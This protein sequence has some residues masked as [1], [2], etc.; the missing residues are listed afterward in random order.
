MDAISDAELHTLDDVIATAES[1]LRI[2]LSPPPIRTLPGELCERIARRVLRKAWNKNHCFGGR[3]TARSAERHAIVLHNG[4][5]IARAILGPGAFAKDGDAYRLVAE[6]F[7]VKRST[8]WPTWR[9]VVDELRDEW[10]KLSTVDG[11]KGAR[12]FIPAIMHGSLLLVQSE[13]SRGWRS[14]NSLYSNPED[15]DDLYPRARP[16]FHASGGWSADIVQALIAAGASVNHR[17]TKTSMTALMRACDEGCD[18]IVQALIAAGADVNARDKE[19]MTPL[20]YACNA[21]HMRSMKVWRLLRAGALIHPQSLDGHTAMCYAFM[22]SESSEIHLDVINLLLNAG[23]D[24]NHALFGS[25]SMLEIASERGNLALVK[26]L[27]AAGANVNVKFDGTQ[28][29]QKNALAAASLRGHVDVVEVLLAAGAMLNPQHWA[30]SPYDF[31]NTA[32]ALHVAITS[33]DRAKTCPDRA[34]AVVRTLLAARADVNDN[35]NRWGVPALVLATQL[36][37]LRMMRALLDAGADVNA[38][39]LDVGAHG[40]KTALAYAVQLGRGP[41]VEALRAAGATE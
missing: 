5:S 7:E 13:L 3:L 34:L 37:N 8:K 10:K 9:A 33:P 23:A 18:D 12:R 11:V 26:A 36:G 28:V 39:T 16:L 20:M 6:L 25:E 41:V 31:L 29:G 27:L 17:T 19:R 1:Q 22:S 24:A 38:R 35:R 30:P 15:I 4:P 21:R 32:S 40:G 14:V 2:G